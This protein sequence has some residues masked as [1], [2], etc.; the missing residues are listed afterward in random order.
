MFHDDPDEVI[1]LLDGLAQENGGEP[2]ITDDVQIE[3]FMMV[4]DELAA[5]LRRLMGL[6]DDEYEIVRNSMAL[7]LKRPLR[8][9]RDG[10]TVEGPPFLALLP[11]DRLFVHQ[12]PDRHG[13]DIERT[14]P[15]NAV[16]GGGVWLPRDKIPSSESFV[17]F[18][19]DLNL[20]N[21]FS[22]DRD[23]CRGW[24]GR[25]SRRYESGSWCLYGV[26]E[27]LRYTDILK[28]SV[29][30]FER[31]DP[32]VEALMDGPLRLRMAPRHRPFSG[33]P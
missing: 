27:I 4:A 18:D 28:R 31:D 8:D 10:G 11:G 17:S 23:S 26:S 12:N 21:M 9:L 7:W 30:E 14:S 25:Y 3:R 22:P 5:W 16:L 33:E 20:E 32:L 2:V 24:S 6:D 15:L 19:F 1:E 29:A 13:V